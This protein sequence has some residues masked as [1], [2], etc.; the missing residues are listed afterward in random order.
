[1]EAIKQVCL[2][3]PQ[4]AKKYCTGTSEKSKYKLCEKHISNGARYGG[5]KRSKRIA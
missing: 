1:M 5:M 4:F 3:C 2:G